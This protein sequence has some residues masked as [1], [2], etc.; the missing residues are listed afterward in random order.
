MTAIINNQSTSQNLEWL[1]TDGTG[2][3]NYFFLAKLMSSLARLRFFV[4]SALTFCEFRIGLKR[5]F[6]DESTSTLW[7]SFYKQ[8]LTSFGDKLVL[9]SNL[10]E[11]DCA[12]ISKN[13]KFLKIF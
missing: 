7:N 8:T 6:D 11:N 13:N 3:L 1:A 5:S 10:K 9:E 12:Q 4:S 2:G